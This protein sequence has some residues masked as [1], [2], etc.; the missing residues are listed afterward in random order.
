MSES[1]TSRDGSQRPAGDGSGVKLNQ[2]VARA[3]AILRAAAARPNGETASGL[4]RRSGLAWATTVRL[5]RTLEQ[6]G[7]LYRLG[8]DRYVLGLELSRLAQS[9]DQGRLL[10]A[11][12]RPLLERLAEKVGETVNLTV[13]RSDGVSEIVEQIDPPRLIRTSDW[14]GGPYPLHASSIGKLLLSTYDDARLEEVLAEPLVRF[15]RATITD[16][17]LLRQEIALVRKRQ[18]STAVD[19]LEDGLAAIGVGI[20]AGWGELLAIVTVSGP[21]FR[22]DEAARA[23]ALVHVR[24]TAQAIER[25]LAGASGEAVARS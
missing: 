7:L 18:H 5:I 1:S 20:T 10:S 15:A 21:T 25:R 2:S 3:A 22:F 9:A 19:E 24:A 6:E 14:L 12:A 4:A 13:V 8:D 16:P 17:G 11:I 23:A